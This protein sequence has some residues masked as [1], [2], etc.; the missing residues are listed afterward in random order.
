MEDEE[1]TQVEE[2]QEQQ[3]TVEHQEQRQEP[4]QR[5][6]EEK[7]DEY[8]LEALDNLGDDFWEQAKTEPAKFDDHIRQVAE[9]DPRTAH[10]LKALHKDYKRKTAKTAEER[11]LAEE[12]ASELE[13]QRKDFEGQV[14]RFQRT[15]RESGLANIEIPAGEIEE[16]GEADYTELMG[17]PTKFVE[18]IRAEVKN[19]LLKE[20]N[21]RLGKVVEPI[22][23]FGE[24]SVRNHRKAE[25]ERFIADRKDNW[26]KWKAD[27]DKTFEQYGKKMPIEDV[28]RI[29]ESRKMEAQRQEEARRVRSAEYQRQGP[30]RHPGQCS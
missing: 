5:Q 13:R 28:Y 4:E 8:S 10:L 18:R 25:I 22:K 11:R 27:I 6:E 26:T 2:T 29:V 24:Q 1:T 23:R 19:E 14:E 3:E 16:L 17:D 12:R 20:Q 9:T 30:A 15:L 21:E 7:P